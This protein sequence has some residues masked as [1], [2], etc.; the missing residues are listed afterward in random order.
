MHF[1]CNFCRNIF[2]IGK[3][4]FQRS[5]G[6]LRFDNDQSG[7]ILYLLENVRADTCREGLPGNPFHAPRRGDI[8]ADDKGIIFSAFQELGNLI[9][10]GFVVHIGD[11]GG[12]AP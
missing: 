5:I 10:A 1:L 8:A 6:I 11:G 7:T 4:F 2:C 12:N 9:A 3:Q